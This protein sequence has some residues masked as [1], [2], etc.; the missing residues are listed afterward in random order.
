MD[1]RFLN[2]GSFQIQFP[3]PSFS[4]GWFK[5][6][7]CGGTSLLSG[8]QLN[9]YFKQ[10]NLRGNFRNTDATY[11]LQNEVPHQIRTQFQADQ[12]EEEMLRQNGG[13]HGYSLIKLIQRNNNGGFK[14]QSAANPKAGQYH[15]EKKVM[16]GAGTAFNNLDIGYVSRK[17][18]PRN[19]SRENLMSSAEDML[20]GENGQS[21]TVHIY[22][23][24]LQFNFNFK[25]N[26]KVF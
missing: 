10:N 3:T 12:L 22:F 15:T 11:N 26:Y 24:K 20:A 14:Q 19:E 6:V 1:T 25:L 9:D 13:V 4:H 18:K 16:E 2:P 21:T 8:P 17:S 7:P 23:K 5:H